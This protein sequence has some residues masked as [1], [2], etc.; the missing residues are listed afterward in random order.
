MQIVKILYTKLSKNLTIRDEIRIFEAERADKS[1]L[2][3]QKVR[4]VK[5]MLKIEGS[6]FVEK[7]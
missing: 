3:F 1:P 4:I 7:I 5:I 6:F 2:N